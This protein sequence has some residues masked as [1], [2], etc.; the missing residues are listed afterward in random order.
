MAAGH[1]IASAT[2]L[3]AAGPAKQAEFLDDSESPYLDPSVKHNTVR[4]GAFLVL[5]NGICGCDL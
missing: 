5:E 2:N 4:I 1:C 3:I